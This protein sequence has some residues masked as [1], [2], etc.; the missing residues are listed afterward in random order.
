M[1]LVK[2][3]DGDLKKI[4]TTDDRRV[5]TIVQ[6]SAQYTKVLTIAFWTCA[7]VTANTMCINSYV[8]SFFYVPTVV[9]QPD[10]TNA[11]VSFPPVILKSWFPFADQW[12]SFSYVY[13]TQFYVM[14]LGMII[15][16][17]Q[18]VF[19]AGIMI[20]CVTALKILTQ[21]LQELQSVADIVRAVERHRK[22]KRFVREL[23][24]LIT[25]ALFLDFVV[26]SVLLCALLFQTSK[27]R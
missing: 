15:V 11:T 10:G 19:V 8:Q 14:W 12:Q 24:S 13:W 2:A 27:V 26:F 7:M 3:V 1:N 9:Q 18:H 23:E 17:G 21:D 25:H 4:L 20:F 22:I 16:P 5:H 6:R